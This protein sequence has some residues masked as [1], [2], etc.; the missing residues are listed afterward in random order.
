MLYAQ[1][2]TKSAISESLVE[3]C[4][5]RAVIILDGRY[6]TATNGEIAAKECAKR[7][8]LAWSIYQGDTFTRSRKVSGPY[9]VMQTLSDNSAMSANFGA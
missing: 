9:R 2:L 3:A 7:G 8:Y 4:G 5:D 1:F 6:S